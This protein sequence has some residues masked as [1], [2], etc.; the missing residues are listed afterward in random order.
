MSKNVLV[1]NETF[2][3]SC[4]FPV[5]ISLFSKKL[6][7]IIRPPPPP[8]LP[9]AGLVLSVTQVHEFSVAR[10]VP[11]P[12]AN[13]LVSLTPSS[14]RTE[15][16]TLELKVKPLKCMGIMLADLRL[17]IHPL[18]GLSSNR[19]RPIDSILLNIAG[20]LLMLQHEP[21]NPYVEDN[22]VSCRINY[23]PQMLSSPSPPL[24]SL[25]RPGSSTTPF[26][27]SKELK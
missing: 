4:T 8:P 17:S 13:T 16:G 19:R 12:W 18:T 27:S 23:I 11:Q 9:P 26:A 20:R 2:F 6:R 21:V 3:I 7:Q 25:R 5:F 14:I 22:D 15:P 10:S 1:F 24:P